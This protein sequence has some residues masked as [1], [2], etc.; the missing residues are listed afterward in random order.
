VNEVDAVHMLDNRLV[1]A[2]A[3]RGTTPF[4]VLIE[5]DRRRRFGQGRSDRAAAKISRAAD[6]VRSRGAGLSAQV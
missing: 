5:T 3:A 4:A 2:C 6:L 1:A